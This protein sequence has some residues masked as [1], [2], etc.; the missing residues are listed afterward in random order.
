M[1]VRLIGTLDEVLLGVHRLRN[2][3]S[4]VEAGQ[5][6]PC[7]KQPGQYRLYCVVAF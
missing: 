1:K 4:S 7:R 2:T 3:F 6:V 5:P